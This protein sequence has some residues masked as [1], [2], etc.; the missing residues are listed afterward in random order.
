MPPAIEKLTV[1]Y[2]TNPIGIDNPKPR[3]SWILT[4]EAR[5]QYQ[6]A[7]Q[8]QVATEL[9]KL[10]EDRPDLWD[11]GQVPSDQSLHVIYEGRELVSEQIAYWRVRVWDKRGTPTAWS[12]P[13]YWSMGLLGRNEWHGEWIGS[14]VSPEEEWIPG[15]YLRRTFALNRPV[16]R[17]TVYASALGL[18]ELRINGRK[19]GSDRF[20]PGWTD[21]HTRVL[22]QAYDVTDFLTEGGNAVGAILGTGWYAG[23]VGMM[24]RGVYGTRPRL[25]VQLHVEYADGTGERIVTDGSWRTSTGAILYSDIIKGE[26]QDTRLEPQGWD[27][28]DFQDLT[29]YPA[30]VFDYYEGTLTAQ[31]DPPILV[32]ESLTPIAAH[33]TGPQ[34]FV[35]DFGQNMA[36]WTR[37]R[38][39]GTEGRTIKVRHAEMLN[40]DGTLYTENLRKAVQED[41]YVLRGGEALWLEPHFTYHGFRYVEVEGL[42]NEL[43]PGDLLAQAAYSSLPTTGDFETSDPAVNRLY[44]NIVWGQK[45]NFFSVPTDCPQRDER[46]GWTGDAQVFVRTASYNMNVAAFFRKYMQDV[47]DAQREDG[48]FPDTAP[49]AN[50]SHFKK[51][52]SANWHAPDNAGWGDAGVIIPWTMYLMYGDTK[53]LE[54]HYEAMRKW[55]DYCESTCEG[56]IRPGYAD[57]ADWLSVGA[58]TPKDVLATLYFAY[59]TRLFVRIAGVLGRKADVLAYEELFKRI[60][61]AFVERFVARDG[62]IEGDTQSLY[63]MALYFEVLPDFLKPQAVRRLAELVRENDGHL[64]T[65]FLGVGCLL[66]ALTEHGETELAYELLH[67]N[68]FPSW[69]YSVRHGATTIWERWDGWTEEN[70]FQSP[71]MNSF[72]HYSL[73][74]VGEWMFRFAAG[75]EPDPERPAFKHIRLK[76]CPGGRLTSVNARYESGYGPIESNWK[77]EPDGQFTLSVRIPPNAYATV[78]LPAPAVRLEDGGEHPPGRETYR[79]GSGSYTFICR[80]EARQASV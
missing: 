33:R 56:L 76:P 4:D 64:S 58:E 65:G 79:I 42:E 22:Y 41:V 53:I 26:K 37:L 28:A 27:S 19:V 49:D 21:Y 68:T 45:G 10:S 23:T 51:V 62:K 15:L 60:Q 13:A 63:A 39:P 5:N 24:G 70:G 25:L 31:Q 67:Q 71:S 38:V 6:T 48:A 35:Y 50:W 80:M 12:E 20:A 44:R 75:L 18:Y 7:Y 8:I 46:L 69:L 43:P 17:A 57:H 61:T 29:W 59:S 52:S 1:D 16:R 55:I 9:A 32:M 36:G 40:P 66:P 77:L 11:S 47:V 14:G 73:G 34:S 78:T 72:N 3:F 30:E 54:D 74:S 2:R